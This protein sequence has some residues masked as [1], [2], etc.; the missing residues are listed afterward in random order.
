MAGVAIPMVA[1]ILIPGPAD[2]LALAAGTS[3]GSVV[4][5]GASRITRGSQVTEQVIREAMKEASLASQQAGGV[6][7]PII[8]KYVDK[9]LAGEVAP[10]IKVDGRMIIDGNHRYMAGRILGKEPAIQPWAGGRPD[11]IIP[12]NKIPID[13][14]AWP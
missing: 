6:S 3:G 2:D 12:W 14:K 1:A 11:S 8:Q 13:P 9:L 5:R 4:A 7:L 10:A